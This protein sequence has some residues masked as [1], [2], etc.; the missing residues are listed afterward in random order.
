VA[1][2]PQP[3]AAA[4]PAG[5]LPTVVIIGAMKCGTTSLH[6]YLDL[7]PEVAMSRPKEL[8]FFIGADTPPALPTDWSS[9]NWH[10][11]P[12]WYAAQFDAS[13]PVRGEASPGYTSPSH[14]QVAMRM[15]WLIP[16]SRLVYAVRDPVR[17]AVSQY[18]HHRREGSEIRPLEEALL[19]PRSQ[20]V[21]RGRYFERLEPFLAAGFGDRVSLV[22]Q[23]ELHAHRR[24]TLRRL[25]GHLGV[26]ERYW[27]DAMDERRNASPER[28]GRLPARLAA[29]LA[30]AFRDDAERLRAFA[31]RDFPRWSV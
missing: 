24:P 29:R 14:P 16:S 20:Y 6:H 17:R 27:S 26:E 5:A 11:G 21:A 30:E 18:W 23:E 31:R 9:G 10:R 12:A 8:N 3:D 28:P 19:D 15:A 25:F 22:A 13:V 2:R 7:H 4:A 1:D